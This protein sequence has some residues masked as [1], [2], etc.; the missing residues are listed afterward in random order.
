KSATIYAQI[1]NQNGQIQSLINQA[2]AF[3]ALGLYNRALTILNEVNQNLQQQPNSPLK[4]TALLSLGNNLSVAGDL[5]Q[6]Q[7][8]LQESWEIAQT[9]K[10]SQEQSTILL[11]LGNVARA[12]KN[13]PAA[14][15][16]Y[17]QAQKNASPLVQVKAQLNHLNTL[18]E[19][20]KWQQAQ[21]LWLPILTQLNNLPS[22]RSSIYAQINL[23]QSLMCLKQSTVVK[24][25]FSSPIVQQC[26]AFKEAEN[27]LLSNSQDLTDITPE[28]SD[29]E[30]LLITASEK[31][32][33]LQ[34]KQA[35]AYALGYRG[36]L[37][38]QTQRLTD[39]NKFTRQA[40]NLALTADARDIA[41][42]WQWQLGRIAKALGDSQQA[43]SNYTIAFK[44]LQSLRSDLVATNPDIQFFFRESVEPIYRELVD[45]LL[46]QKQPNLIL[47]REVIE[48]LQ[49]AELDDFFREACVTAEPKQI[50]EIVEKANP[51]TAVFYAFFLPNSLEVILKLPGEDLQ[52]Y[53]TPLNIKIAKNTIAKLQQALPQVDRAKDVQILSQEVYK[54]LI[55]STQERLNRSNVKTLVFVLDG[56]LRNIPMGVLYDGQKYLV[57][58]YAIALTPG[59]Q[60]INPRERAKIQLNALT[61]GVSEQRKVEGLEF[62]KLENVEPE[63]REVKFQVRGSE[64]LLN[65]QFTKKNLE[66]QINK[67]G[68]SIV[69]L[70][71]HGQFSSDPDKTFLLLWDKLIKARDLNNLLRSTDTGQAS[72][73]IELLV[74]SACQTASGDDRAALGLAGVAVSAGA[75]STI[76]SLWPVNDEST[77]LLMKRFYQELANPNITKAEALQRAQIALLNQKDEPYHW[78]PYILVGN[79]L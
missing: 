22:S 50:D 56:A 2:Q 62:N 25:E 49:L 29:I 30:R 3:Q 40:L 26:I 69:H 13:I 35:E 38:Q 31:A 76:A 63:L 48:S 9:L 74:L 32:S 41:Y 61:A 19:A 36:G 55:A 37:Y 27:K 72:K 44:N 39:A 68:F 18:I 23:A 21:A 46:K 52:H 17:Q 47:T 5:K 20:R 11:S 53:S 42:R 60:L 73:T 58:K 64:E 10:L 79:W 4:V 75:R 15:N 59:L 34:D 71:T 7:Q 51:R 33:T 66:R 24:P 1:S 12:Q 67:G 70:A 8:I 45:L 77:S 14:I 78:A 43:I 28:W 16:Y 65:Q 6:A 54:W 57:E